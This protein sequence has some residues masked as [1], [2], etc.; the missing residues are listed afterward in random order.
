MTAPAIEV[1]VSVIWEDGRLRL[2]DQRALPDRITL[3]TLSVAVP[4]LL[5][6]HDGLR[7]E[8]FSTDELAELPILSR[9]SLM[10]P[11]PEWAL[12]SL[13]KFLN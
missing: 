8:L 10:E 6:Q 3:E 1:P 11:I 7:A 4:I 2:L 12:K 9:W 5:M 13:E